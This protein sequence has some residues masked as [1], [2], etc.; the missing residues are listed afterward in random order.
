MSEYLKNVAI[1][2]NLCEWYEYFLFF[3]FIFVMAFKLV[4]IDKPISMTFSIR[5]LSRYYTLAKSR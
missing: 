5:K 4:W 3:F 1:Y 2:N